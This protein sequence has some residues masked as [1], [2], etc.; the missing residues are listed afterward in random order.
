MPRPHSKHAP[1]FKGTSLDD[2]LEDFEAIARNAGVLNTEWP[3]TL[4]RYCVQEVRDV[5][6]HLPVFQGSDWA[7]AK[8][9]LTELYQSN[10]KRRRVTADKLREFVADS[11][12]TQSFRSRKDLDVYTRQFLAM[13]GELKRRNL[14]T[15]NEINLRFYKGLPREV[16]LRIRQ[17]LKSTTA[18]S[19]PAMA[20]VL[21]LVR[22]LYSEDDIDAESDREDY[23][24]TDDEDDSEASTDEERDDEPAKKKRKDKEKSSNPRVKATPDSVVPGP[25]GK[26]QENVLDALTKQMEEL[27]IQVAEQARQAQTRRIC[28]I[29]DTDSHRVG[30]R[31]CPE[32]DKLV[33]EGLLRYSQGKLVRIDGSDLPLVRPG[34]GGVANA[35]RTERRAA[36]GKERDPPPHQ[37]MNVGVISDTGE[38]VLTGEVYAVAVPFSD[39]EDTYSYPA[40]RTPKKDVRFDPLAKKDDGKA[41]GIKLKISG[42]GQPPS[43]TVQHPERP[44]A[45]P[46]PPTAEKAP[47]AKVPI[48]KRK[49]PAASVADDSDV[50]MQSSSSKAPKAKTPSYRF[51]SD[52][53]ESVNIEQVQKAILD[54]PITLPL[55]ELLAS[56]ADLQKRFA[57]LTKT[58][59]E[60]AAKYGEYLEADSDQI[61]G[62]RNAYLSLRWGEDAETIIGRY[63]NSVS[64]RPMRLFAMTTGR[65]EAKIADTNLSAMIDTGSELNLISATAF[66]HLNIPLDIDGARW[67]LRGI[68]GEPVSLQGCARDVPIE[69]GGH[70]FGHH[71]F[72]TQAGGSIGKQDIILGQPWLQWYA[73]MIRYSRAGPMTLTI[74]PKGDEGD[75]PAVSLKLVAPHHDRNV[76]RLVQSYERHDAQDFY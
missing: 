71:F 39:D 4:P 72:V 52:V 74:Y 17:D 10:D 6:E 54:T 33:E 19:A 37:S 45:Q 38:D 30:Y 56:S 57:N 1:R 58:R 53:Q 18:S 32:A 70:R 13:S 7:I 5:I 3:R 20:D 34:T 65:F 40:A 28:W 27:R 15:D 60:Y 76:D 41:T 55:R 46:T 21:T 8:A 35:L 9:A 68:S 2:F 26:S 63:A 69:I 22:K 31:N 61:E 29:C 44:P 73:A 14:I 47:A 67:S 11:A 24:D 75:G 12:K 62:A 16:K 25:S 49:P 64:V 59:R 66:E 50:G 36:R 43:I 23:L 48:A 42:K 51:T